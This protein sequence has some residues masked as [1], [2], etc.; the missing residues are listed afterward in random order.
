MERRPAGP[1]RIVLMVDAARLRLT[2][3]IAAAALAE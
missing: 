2:T 1:M 3:P